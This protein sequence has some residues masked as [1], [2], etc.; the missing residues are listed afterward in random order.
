MQRR[1]FLAAAAALPA[2]YALPRLAH[3]QQLPFEPKAAANWRTFEIVTRVEV[4][5]PAGVVRAWVPVPAVDETWQRVEGNAWTGNASSVR[6]VGDGKYGASMVAAEWAPGTAAPVLVVTS[7]FA[8]RDRAVTWGKPITD[9]KLDAATK[10]FYTE[11]TDYLPTDGIVRQTALEIT[12]GKRSDLDKARAIYDW[13]VDNTFRDP[14]TRGCGIGDI[15]AMLETGN[16][17]GKCADL[18]ALFVG[19]ARSVGLPGARRLRPARGEVAVRL[20]QPRRRLEQR[21]PRAALP[22]RGVP[23]RLRLGAGRSR[24]RAQGRAGGERRSRPT[25]RRSAGEGGARASS[26]ARGR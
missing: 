7:Q 4:Q 1:Q 15:K 22:R 8:T 24:R 19:L 14:K 6:V 10:R 20:P 21:H 18:N 25:L 17:G 5:K 23:H 12:R 26:S 9:E 3:A 2:A 16:L 13:I 11:A